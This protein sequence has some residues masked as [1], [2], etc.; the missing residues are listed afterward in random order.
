MQ[1]SFLENA[2]PLRVSVTRGPIDPPVVDVCAWSPEGG[3][4]QFHLR[5]DLAHAQ[6]LIDQLIGACAS[7]EDDM[8]DTAIHQ[9]M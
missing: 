1:I 5:L 2:P 9:Q 3:S 7:I 6:D 4:L 8:F